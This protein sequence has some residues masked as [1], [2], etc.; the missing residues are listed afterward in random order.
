M[1]C[2]SCGNVM[3]SKDIKCKACGAFAGQMGTYN[4]GNNERSDLE[5]LEGEVIKNVKDLGGLINKEGKVDLKKVPNIVLAILG[6]FFSIFSIIIYFILKDEAP[7]KAVVLKN[8]IIIG[9]LIRF[10]VSILPGIVI[11]L[12]EN[13]ELVNRIIYSIFN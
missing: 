1:V 7:N 2:K 4:A 8:W 6:L 5:R 3:A 11:G 10:V 12:L 9:L 13:V